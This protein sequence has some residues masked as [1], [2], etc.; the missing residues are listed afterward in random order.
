MLL[1]GENKIP[2][3]YA[4]LKLCNKNGSYFHHDYNTDYF[5]LWLLRQWDIWPCFVFSACGEE[6][7]GKRDKADSVLQWERGPL[8]SHYQ[9][10][11][12]QHRER[13]VMC[14]RALHCHHSLVYLQLEPMLLMIQIMS[15]LCRSQNCDLHWHDLKSYLQRSQF[16]FIQGNIP[17]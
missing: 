2:T 5:R 15:F 12:S 9:S 13:S 7:L 17:I 1:F 3:S 14:S 11:C 4:S 6:D 10:G 16:W 8:H